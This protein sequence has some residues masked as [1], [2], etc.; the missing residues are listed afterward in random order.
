VTPSIAGIRSTHAFARYTHDK[1]QFEELV[2]AIRR[3]F[4]VLQVSISAPIGNAT[5][6]VISQVLLHLA[7][8]WWPNMIRSG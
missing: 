3:K 5:V 4:G 2:S 7:A 8:P 1:L 6:E